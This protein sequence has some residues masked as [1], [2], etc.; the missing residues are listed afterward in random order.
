MV[1]LQH[2]LFE[3]PGKISESFESAL[4]QW[5]VPSKGQIDFVIR[6]LLPVRRGPPIWPNICTDTTVIPSELVIAQ[7]FAD[8]MVKLNDVRVLSAS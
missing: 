8:E 7:L 5:D 6:G 4:E 3:A 2:G 1:C